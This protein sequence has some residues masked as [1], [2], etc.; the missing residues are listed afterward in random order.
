MAPPTLVSG[1]EDIQ[2]D[3]KHMRH[4]LRVMAK[5]GIPDHQ[6]NATAMMRY[7]MEF[8]TLSCATDML[9][10]RVF[11]NGKEISE[12]FGAFNAVR[13]RLP[14]FDLKDPNVRV[15]CVADGTTPRTGATFA[16]RSAWTV[17]SIDPLMRGGTQRWS[18]IKRLTT[19]PTRIE[20]FTFQAD[21]VI[22]VAVH[23]HADL[24]KSVAGIKAREL[25][26]VAIPCCVNLDLDV[27]PT[28]VY[29][30]KGI[31]SPCRTVKI[32]ERY[33]VHPNQP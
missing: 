4:T 2:A 14:Q 21:R 22:V 10:M 29:Q 19:I 15:V 1:W 6:P 5:T 23:S 26:V 28:R 25:A 31:I 18:A 32:W 8:V 3:I 9:A 13:Y 12:S 27:K 7:L 33:E 16:L 17:Y 30:D 24:R 20:E 11:P